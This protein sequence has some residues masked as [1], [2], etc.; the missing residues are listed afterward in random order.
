MKR[1][2]SCIAIL[3]LCT[4]CFGQ[5]RSLSHG[6]YDQWKSVRNSKISN[7]G[8]IVTFE[9]NPQKGDGN[10]FIYN[11][12]NNS[13]LII[14]RGYN[15]TITSNSD[16]V[17]T[18]IRPLYNVIRGLKLKKIKKDKFP[19][20]SLYIWYRSNNKLIKIGNVSE[21]TSPKDNPNLL[22]YIKES[23][24]EDKKSDIKSSKELIIYNLKTNNKKIFKDVISYSVAKNGSIVLIN[25]EVKTS[26]KMN[27]LITYNVKNKNIRI[28]N[29][30]KDITFKNLTIDSKGKQIA[31]IE[32]TDTLKNNNY[33]LIFINKTGRTYNINS[34]NFNKK[35]FISPKGKLFFSENNK[36]LFFGIVDHKTINRKDSLTDDEKYH[37]DV[38]N[39]RD[40]FINPY[41]KV[42]LKEEKERTYLCVFN[43]NNSKIFQIENTKTNTS[44]I[45]KKGNKSIA[46]L[47]DSSEYG[48]FQDFSKL[49]KD[50]Y[51]YNLDTGNKTKVFT[52]SELNIH[53]SPKQ[54][55]IVFFQPKDSL[56]YSYNIK[57]KKMLAL[58]KNLKTAFYNQKMDM[59]MSAI[60]Y[61][62]QTWLKNDKYVLIAD[63]YDIW[64]FD[65][66]GIEA[67]INLTNGFGRSNNVKLRY[68]KLNNKESYPLSK[69]IILHGFN[70]KNKKSG[71]YSLNIKKKNNPKE[72]IYSNHFYNANN[73]YK[74]KEG[75]N[76][77]F[78]KESFKLYPDLY[79]SDINFKKITKLSTANP[80]QKEYKWG[81]VN[82]EHWTNGDGVEMEGLLYTPEKMEK[83]KK[84][85]MLVYFYEKSSDTYN[86]HFIP[87]PNWSIINRS[88][89]TS[90]DYIIFVPNITYKNKTG[91][92][93]EAAYSSIVTG[94]LNMCQKYNFI[95]KKNI[96]LQGQSWG[97]YQIAYLVTRTNLFKCAMAGAPVSNMTSAY[98]GIRWR[99]GMSRQFQYEQTQ[100]RQGG[101]LWNSTIQYIEN[102]PVFFVPKIKTPLLIMHNDHDGAVPWYQGIELFMA[103]RRFNKPCWMLSYNNE[104]HN[105]KRRANRIDLSIRTMQFFDYYL[106]GEKEPVWMKYG[107][108][109]H[110]KE[111]MTGYQ[112]AK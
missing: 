83:N 88:Y 10:L 84:Y 61:G 102:S 23:N 17:I 1:I 40:N 65:C 31:Y 94:V 53:L 110:K 70:Y 64:K 75:K 85:P 52:K 49:Y 7:D 72:L 51:T 101:T 32:N 60:P 99:T 47:F 46:L 9:I 57:N 56:W 86:K 34:N 42:N 55:Y 19:K 37:L 87:Q 50:I 4:H 92:P 44:K 41:Q 30:G 14:K 81:N 71:Y 63:K 106:K 79:Y 15:T 74:S 22:L 39:Y 6:D 25:Q 80:Q 77:I 35:S 27:Q 24:I 33:K 59:P 13:K 66:S 48:R 36:R 98:G 89:C 54:K 109:A 91:Y 82:L 12:S 68:K 8:K 69:N 2:I 96:G 67:P 105:L 3:M 103:M 107:I 76:I 93:G 100:S 11:Y 97:G 21:Y 18:K 78:T 90:N 73:I 108:P 112:L 58:N 95:D 28:L 111:Y 104:A 5:N 45:Y 20:D 26:I 29:K 43:I 62:L 38:W 16:Y